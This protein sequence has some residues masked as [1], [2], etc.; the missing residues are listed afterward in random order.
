M[1]FQSKDMTHVSNG[2]DLM[3]NVFHWLI[4][5]IKGGG[6]SPIHSIFKQ[7]GICQNT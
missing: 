7:E 6:D 1:C 2:L 4:K 5:K 3:K